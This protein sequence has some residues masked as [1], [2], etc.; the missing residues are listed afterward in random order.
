MS[1]LTP[2]DV[3]PLP[4]RPDTDWERKHARA[5]VRVSGGK[6]KLDEARRLA[7]RGYGF[8]SSRKAVA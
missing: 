3:R 6:L 5:L 7:G 1:P 2:V 4:P 8:S